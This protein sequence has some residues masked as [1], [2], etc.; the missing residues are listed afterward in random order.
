MYKRQGIVIERAPVEI[1]L[2]TQLLAYSYPHL[3]LDIEC[4][5]GTYIRSLA[6]DL[7]QMLGCGAHLTSLQ[8][9]RS[10]SIRIGDCC[11]VEQLI[12]PLSN[13]KQFLRT[14]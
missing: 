7:G 3:D 13:W 5:K 9:V 14:S 2:R 6:H 10:G 12:D 1:T 8:R 4:S 11:E